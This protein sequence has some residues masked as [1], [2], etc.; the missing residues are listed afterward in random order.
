MDLVVAEGLI[1]QGVEPKSRSSWTDLGCGR[2]LFTRALGDILRDTQ[3]A[4]YAVD[5][6]TKTLQYVT[7]KTPGVKLIRVS[8]DFTKDLSS[9]P[10]VDGVLMA[11][12]FHYVKD[13]TAFLVQ[14][15]KKLTLGGRIIMVEYDTNV[16]NTWVPYPVSG[17]RLSELMQSVGFY[18]RILAEHPSI[19]HNGNIYSALIQMSV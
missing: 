3:S 16:P 8:A 10:K 9:I 5:I 6:D 7:I 14:L 18:C 13:K 17:E 1:R 15:K 12:S 11:N 4:I 2:G 19:Y